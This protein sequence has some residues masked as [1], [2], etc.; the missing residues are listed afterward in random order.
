VK[1][2]GEVTETETGDVVIRGTILDITDHESP[3][4]TDP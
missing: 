2:R 4:G 3:D 1:C